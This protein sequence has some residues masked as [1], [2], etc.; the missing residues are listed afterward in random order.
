MQQH[1]QHQPKHPHSDDVRSTQ[2]G[3]NPDKNPSHKPNPNEDKPQHDKPQPDKPR[4]DD[5]PRNPTRQR[6]TFRSY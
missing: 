4:R 3:S 6:Q 1:P 2:A 5:A